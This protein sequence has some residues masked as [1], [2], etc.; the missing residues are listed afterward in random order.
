MQSRFSS[1]SVASGDTPYRTQ[2]R[3]R[4]NHASGSILLCDSCANDINVSRN[5]LFHLLITHADVAPGDHR[6]GM[7]QKPLNQHDVVTV[8]IVDA[9]CVPLAKA[10]CAD[11]LIAEMVADELEMVLDLSCADGKQKGVVWDLV[12]V[13]VLSQE[14]V[15]LIG[16]GELA[17]L[18]GLL[19]HHI[20]TVAVAISHDV[21][22][23]QPQN[24]SHAHPKIR[25]GCEDRRHSWVRA[26]VPKAVQKGLYDGAVLNVG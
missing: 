7:L 4:S 18:P 11:V 25:L 2:K 16:N 10:V 22:H 5:R 19:F 9:C 21:A 6:T 15:D 1:A 20:E 24:V 26:A 13:C 23:P 14:A 3:A 17:T 12:R 8:L